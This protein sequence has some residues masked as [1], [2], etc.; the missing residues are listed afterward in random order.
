MSAFE[1]SYELRPFAMPE[2][3]TIAGWAADADEV[4]FLTGTDDFPLTPGDVAAWTYE[5]DYALTLRRGGD[6]AAYAEIVEDIV[7]QDVEIQHLLVA[8]DLRSVAVGRT[9][10]LRCCAFLSEVRDYPEVWLR[11]SRDNAPAAACVSAAGFET[12]T[13]M[14]GPRYLWMKKALVPK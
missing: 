7:E 9:M 5:A 8:P 6:L 3:E 12:V 14:S 2:A 10:L 1:V 13:Q 11:V 4:R